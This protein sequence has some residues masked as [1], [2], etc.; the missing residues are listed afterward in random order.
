M[1]KTAITHRKRKKIEDNFEER[2]KLALEDKKKRKAVRKH[3]GESRLSIS[4]SKT[5]QSA[6]DKTNG[7]VYNDVRYSVYAKRDVSQV[8]Q[9]DYDHHYW[10]FAN[11]VI[12]KS[13]WGVVNSAI[14]DIKL[15]KKY[16]QTVDGTYMI[17]TGEYKGADTVYNKIVFT[18]GLHEAPSVE[19][20]I[21]IVS[22]NKEFLKEAREVIYG[23]GYAGIP[24]KDSQ[25][26]KVYTS[27]TY[28][29]AN[30]VQNRQGSVQNYASNSGN[31]NGSRIF[32][33][34]E[35]N[36]RLSIDDSLDLKYPNLNLDQEI[37]DIYKAPAVKLNDGSIVPFNIVKDR[38]KYARHN[39]AIPTT[40]TGIAF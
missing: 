35:G 31:Q 2:D 3:A 33:K 4:D 30:F 7:K 11:N 27:K 32:S 18:D 14:S 1:W 28:G 10:A 9:E 22:T 13:E 15:R 37:K 5:S 38:P 19:M 21:E 20:V 26:F 29:Y 34:T 12:S 16:P 17:P 25:V 23:F 36:R 24:F 39:P 40:S 8:T 6:I